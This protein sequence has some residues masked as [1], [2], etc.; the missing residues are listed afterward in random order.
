MKIIYCILAH[1]N[2]AILRTF[3]EIMSR[4]NEIY[5]HIDK[6]SKMKNFKEYENKVNILKKRVNV[7][8]GSFSQIKA[9]LLMLEE[10]KNEE[11]DYVSLVSGDCL[12]IMSSKRIN[13]RLEKDYGKEFIGYQ[14]NFSKDELICR[15][16]YNY[17][18]SHYN[19][20]KNSYNNKVIL[21]H[22]KLRK[23][24]YNKNYEL[25]PTLY[26]G[27]QWFT[28]SKDCINFVLQYLKENK[29]YKKAFKNSL[30]SDEIFFQT[31]IM[32]SKFK[33]NIYKYDIS[34]NG[35]YMSLRYIDWQSGPEYP[36][37]LDESDFS[38]IKDFDCIL[39]R[40]FNENLDLNKYRKFFEIYEE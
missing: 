13:K 12:P 10:I 3:I 39:A 31:I 35:N 38:K 17:L 36:K 15:V 4:E 26:K 23:Y 18:P 34:P 25:L 30:C 14:K 16:K 28:L 33:N 20:Y 19:K 9:T 37:L 24:F 22:S 29:Y 2:T 11:Y 32:N 1:K 27:N 6:K 21:I 7:K 8:W 40:K 5:L